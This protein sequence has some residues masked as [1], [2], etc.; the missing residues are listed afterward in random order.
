M[1]IVMAQFSP[2]FFYLLFCRV[3]VKKAIKMKQKQARRQNGH[4]EGVL[5][6]SGQTF[7]L[8]FHVFFLIIPRVF[9]HRFWPV[10]QKAHMHIVL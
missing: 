2:L 9:S 10:V 3:G 8:F 7:R 6:G 4:A 5:E 1:L